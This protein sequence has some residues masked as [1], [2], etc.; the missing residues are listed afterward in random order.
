M[1][2]ASACTRISNGLAFVAMLISRLLSCLFAVEI[3]KS[4][5]HKNIINAYVDRAGIDMCM[6]LRASI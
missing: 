1:G 5:D 2:A 3:L 4:L 6:R